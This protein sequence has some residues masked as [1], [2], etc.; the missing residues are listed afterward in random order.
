MSTVFVQYYQRLVSH[1]PSKEQYG[2]W[3]R[4]YES[5]IEGVV[6]DRYHRYHLEEFSVCSQLVPGDK[7]YVIWMTFSDGD[8][9]GRSRGEIEVIWVFKDY[10]VARDAKRAI[11]AA[12]EADAQSLTFTDEGGIHRCLSNP[13]YDYFAN[14]ESVNMSVCEVDVCVPSHYDEEDQ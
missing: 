1:Q 9:F 3:S 10:H 5:G 7:A 2:D 6:L 13:C 11:E 4:Q 8:S 14:L 12:I